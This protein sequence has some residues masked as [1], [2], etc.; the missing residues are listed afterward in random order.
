MRT[1][2]T[3]LAAAAGCLLLISGCQGIP[4]LMTV[5]APPE[6]VEALH[7]LDPDGR[8]LL[9][10]VDSPHC[11]PAQTM[12][13]HRHLIRQM[14]VMLLANEATGSVVSYD[15]ILDLRIANPKTFEEWSP[16]RIAQELNADQI[17][18]IEIT[19][20]SVKDDAVDLTWHGQLE[21]SIS[22][23]SLDGK[24]VWPD[25]RLHG[26]PAEPVEIRRNNEATPAYTAKLTQLLSV[27]MADNVSK[28]F[29]DHEVDAYDHNK[30]ARMEEMKSQGLFFE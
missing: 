8:L 1:R 4:Y 21:A 23:I 27:A 10:V 15:E 24:T 6:D 25:D 19:K 11:D 2:T 17:V 5:L 13:V 20:F 3:L 16:A 9:L 30:Q 18:Q 14:T 7:D 12:A 29:Y 22:A 28:Y 26:F